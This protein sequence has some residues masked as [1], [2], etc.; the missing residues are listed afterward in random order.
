MFRSVTWVAVLFLVFSAPIFAVPANNE[1]LI[2]KFSRAQQLSAEGKT[3]EAI[4]IYQALIKSNPLLP[5]AYNNLAGLYLKQ[6]NTKQAK[7]VL[8]QGLHAHKS[9][10]VL[11]ESLTAINVAMA[12]EAY[13]KALQIEVKPSDIQANLLILF[14]EN[15][16]CKICIMR[17]NFGL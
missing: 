7:Y 5:E 3:D 1:E 6:K 11:Y 17:T 16:W 15:I 2:Q 13:S 8:E 4:A 9:Y 14:N 12:R 10:G